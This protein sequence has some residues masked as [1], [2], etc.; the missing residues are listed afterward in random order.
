MASL[1]PHPSRLATLA[2]FLACLMSWWHERVRTPGVVL[3]S[4]YDDR[5][6]MAE[7]NGCASR[8][9]EAIRKSE[10]FDRKIGYEVNDDKCQLGV[11]C[12]DATKLAH[13]QFLERW[14]KP[15]VV[16]V[17]GVN[18][19]ILHKVVAPLDDELGERISTRAS[20][21]AC[22]ARTPEA[23]RAHVLPMLLSIVVWAAPFAKM[24]EKL[25]STTKL[26]VQRCVA[27]DAFRTSSAMLS[28][29]VALKGIDPSVTWMQRGM[30]ATGR[31]NFV[32]HNKH[33]EELLPMAV[34]L[35]PLDEIA[36]EFIKA[37]NN[38]GLFY[39][40]DGWHRLH[41][42]AGEERF[43]YGHDSWEVLDD[44]VYEAC[45]ISA[46]KEERRVWKT[47]HRTLQD[48][49]ACG[50]RL[51][52]PEAHKVLPVLDAHMDWYQ[53]QQQHSVKYLAL[54]N[55]PCFWRNGF[56]QNLLYGLRY[57]ERDTAGAYKTCFCGG[58]EPSGAHLLWSCPSTGRHRH[59]LDDHGHVRKLINLPIDRSEER[60]LIR[61]IERKPYAANGDVEPDKVQEI[62]SMIQ[63]STAPGDSAVILGTDGS[64]KD[65]I[66][67][68]A[69]AALNAPPVSAPTPGSDRSN[70]AAELIAISVMLRA[71]TR[72]EA[73]LKRKRCFIYSDCLSA[74]D[75]ATAPFLSCVWWKVQHTGPWS[76]ALFQGLGSRAL[77]PG[78]WVPGLC[79]QG[80]V[81]KLGF[82]GFG[83]SALVPR[84]WFQGF[85]SKALVPGRWFQGF[86]SMGFGSRALVPWLGSMG[87]VP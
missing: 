27:P 14:K 29:F 43:R 76:R 38:V 86:G 16:K 33:W 80:L 78:H 57:G 49:F 39:N 32:M 22:A 4:Y 51:P 55:L 10:E 63:S 85:G 17:L 68:C 34:S 87:L 1:S 21:I 36:P 48:N 61:C 82:L 74:I 26:A 11:C 20:R 77:V 44:W 40:G 79:S 24:S 46:A 31:F 7:G 73:T 2:L 58:R 47:C 41:P 81:P 50:L 70:F 6:L 54:G 66:N 53:Q 45:L 15:R 13:L 30:H 37:A 52:P 64:A 8:L 35:I 71:C 75:I 28:R 83:S 84:L 72:C 56:R 19:D 12:S 25:R 60:N 18:Y 9:E 3:T 67:T 42:L 62:V 5:T 59:V 69:W 23:R 65:G